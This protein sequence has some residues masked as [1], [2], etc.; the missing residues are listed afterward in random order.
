MREIGDAVGLASTSTVHKY[1]RTMI[2]AGLLT[3]ANSKPRSIVPVC[4]VHRDNG[5]EAPPAHRIRVDM[6]DGGSLYFDYQGEQP[7]GSI[8][9]N[10][11]GVFDGTQLKQP[12]C[13]IA[14]VHVVS[15]DE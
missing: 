12:V 11:C 1:I 8:P 7:L 6:S 13:E 5:E 4:N 9:Q 2:D 10:I 3:A 15:P 14:S